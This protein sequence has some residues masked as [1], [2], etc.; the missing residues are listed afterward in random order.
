MA[1]P[2]SLA[3]SITGVLAFAAA[4]ARSL[5]TIVQEIR[6]APDD[7][8]ATGRDV[9]ALAAVLSAAHD[10]C[11]RHNLAAE[12]KDLAAALAEYVDMCQEAMQGLRIILRPLAA[13]AR[14]IRLILG[15]AMKKGE[16]RA[17]RARLNEG[18][19]SLNLTL[20]ALNG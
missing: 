13:G 2:L 7:I 3:A 14:P 5:A 15:W 1:D 4:T 9:R 11:T 6:D 8:V 17:L 19:A 12:D 18:K 20:S 16:V 10:T